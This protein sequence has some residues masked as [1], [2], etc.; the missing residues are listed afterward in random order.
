M[1]RC[2]SIKTKY[3][4]K[5]Q[6]VLYAIPDEDQYVGVYTDISQIKFDAGQLDLIKRQT[7]QQAKDLLDNQIQ[8]SQEMAHYLGNSTAKNEEM[9]KKLIDLYEDDDVSEGE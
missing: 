1:D 2:E 6:E 4:K 5:Y 3:G 9:V 8:F 7:L